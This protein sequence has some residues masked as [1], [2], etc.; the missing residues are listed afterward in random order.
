ML[1]GNKYE[2]RSS[3]DSIIYQC[4][5]QIP[6]ADTEGNVGGRGSGL[7]P[8]KNHKAIG[9]LIDTGPD[10]IENHKATKPVFNVGPP[11]ARHLNL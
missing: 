8:L 7:P 9:F 4:L 3:L 2:P 11:S 10:P 1:S 5:Q 6:C